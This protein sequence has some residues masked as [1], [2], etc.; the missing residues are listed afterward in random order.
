MARISGVYSRINR[1]TY[2]TSSLVI[3]D[4]EKR[5][6]IFTTLQVVA[7][8]SNSS[9]NTPLATTSPAATCTRATVPPIGER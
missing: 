5:F 9:N 2:K 4:K 6:R 3:Y 8:Y 7:V 1:I